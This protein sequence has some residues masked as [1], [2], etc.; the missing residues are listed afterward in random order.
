MALLRYGNSSNKNSKQEDNRKYIRER[1]MLKERKND[2]L[3][4]CCVHK[5]TQA[6]SLQ[7]QKERGT[8]QYT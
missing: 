7:R 3:H 5:V 4:A 6:S 1:N 8:A 2:S